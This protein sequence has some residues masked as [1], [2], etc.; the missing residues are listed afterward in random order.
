MKTQISLSIRPVWSESSPSAWIYLGSLAIHSAH[1]EYPDQTGHWADPPI[2][3]ESS[4]GAQN[5]LFVLSC[6]G[7]YIY[8]S[9]SLSLG[10]SHG[11]G[12][13]GRLGLMVMLCHCQFQ[14]ASNF[15]YRRAQSVLRSTDDFNFGGLIPRLILGCHILSILFSF[16]F[17]RRSTY[18]AY[19]TPKLQLWKRLLN[20]ILK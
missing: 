12:R 3:S 2:W 7:I 19:I 8:I 4:L 16:S 13:L 20:G 17:E 5:T 6:C 14:V 1:S 10:R 18:L 15:D 11:L 9:R